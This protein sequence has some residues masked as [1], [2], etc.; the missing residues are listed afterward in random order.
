MTTIDI[1]TREHNIQVLHR[2]LVEAALDQPNPTPA[3]V[4]ALNDVLGATEHPA[5]LTNPLDLSDGA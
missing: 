1:A 3:L 5:R 2:Y 4:N